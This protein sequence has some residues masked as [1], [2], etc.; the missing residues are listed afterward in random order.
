[1][2]WISS[3]VPW[4]LRR[5]CTHFHL[6]ILS[7][8][9]LFRILV[10]LETSALWLRKKIGSDIWGHKQN[11]YDKLC[12][13]NAYFG[14]YNSVKWTWT[15]LFFYKRTTCFPAVIWLKGNFCSGRYIRTIFREEARAIEIT[16]LRHRL[17]LGMAFLT[18]S[19]ASDR[20][21]IQD[22]PFWLNFELIINLHEET[23]LFQSP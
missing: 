15:D 22:F 5:G 19:A 14:K 8:T 4:G 13:V 11:S 16:F 18:L 1:M 3:D 7:Q 23:F 17:I 2:F 6:F 21:V 12:N 20:M 9:F 10:Y